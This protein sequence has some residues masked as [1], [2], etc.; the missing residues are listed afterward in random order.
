MRCPVC[1]HKDTSVIDSRPAEDGFSI[2]RRRECSKCNYRF[3]TV[4]EMELLDLILVK[5]DGRRETYMRDKMENGVKRSLIKRPYTKE[6]FNR[7][8][9]AIER[10][11]QKK[12]SREISSKDLGEIIMKRL[13]SFDKIAYIRFASVYRDFKDVKSFSRELKKINQNKVK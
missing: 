10:D 9:H 5:R 7:L 13:K 1:Q 11:M 6:M 3:S 2:R 4:E 8:I 12:K